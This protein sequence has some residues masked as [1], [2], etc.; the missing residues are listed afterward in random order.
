MSKLSILIFSAA[1]D[2][3]NSPY[4]PHPVQSTQPSYYNNYAYSQPASSYADNQLS[5]NY[6]N[7]AYMNN[8]SPGK[9]NYPYNG[10]YGNQNYNNYL[11]NPV[12]HGQPGGGKDRSPISYGFNLRSAPRNAV[13]SPQPL[14]R[15]QP[16]RNNYGSIVDAQY[17]DYSSTGLPTYDYYNNKNHFNTRNNYDSRYNHQRYLPYRKAYS[18]SQFPRNSYLGSCYACQNCQQCSEQAYCQGCPKCKQLPCDKKPP[19]EEQYMD[20]ID[21]LVEEFGKKTKGWYLFSFSFNYTHL[22]LGI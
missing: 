14:Q 11:Y 1:Y 20:P 19:K 22:T 10:Y 5:P 3:Q 2:Y 4:I 7:T 17:R 18:G 13:E 21:S 6:Y 8:Q 9:T 12:N 16:P 15:Q